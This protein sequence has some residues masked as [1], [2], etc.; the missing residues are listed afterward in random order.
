MS[1]SPLFSPELEG[2]L[3][4]AA[5]DPRSVLLRVPRESSLPRLLE[6]QE[7]TSALSANLRPVE[8]HL[9]EVYRD[10]LGEALLD[11]CR[12]R[13][14]SD[15]SLDLNVHRVR[16]TTVDWTVESAEQW[17]ERTQ[18]TLEVLGHE[19]SQLQGL[20]LLAAC[21][22]PGR[23][24]Q[25]SIT[26]LARAALRLRSSPRARAW[27]VF[28]LRLQERYSDA[29]RMSGQELSGHPPPGLSASLLEYR[30]SA[31]ASLGH[32]DRAAHD[33]WQSHLLDPEHVSALVNAMHYSLLAED[34]L[35]A[36]R[37]GRSLDELVAS[38]T[39][40]LLEQLEVF[41]RAG[42]AG[43]LPFTS[44]SRTIARALLEFAG[45]LARKVLHVHS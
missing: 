32:F 20:D 42:R 19:A 16:T 3:R 17:A 39:E 36:E 6:R 25:V 35:S 26:Q 1:D 23:I 45:P 38:P 24:A 12:V 40:G 4:E 5:A 34:R 37:A 41:E 15:T 9:L 33:A 21:M 31:E 28:D 13:L 11:A 43:R 44:N 8:R 10:E 27:I 18:P 30:A 29:I 2:L 14:Y 7:P 22:E